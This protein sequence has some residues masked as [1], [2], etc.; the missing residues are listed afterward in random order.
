MKKF[1]VCFVLAAMVLSTAACAKKTEATPVSEATTA[2]AAQLANPWVDCTLKDIQDKTGLDFGTPANAM[3]ITYRLMESEQLGEMNFT[4]NGA[5]CCARV[6][7]S[8]Q[9]TDISGMNYTWSTNTTAESTVSGQ[10]RTYTISKTSDNKVL[11]CSWFDAVPGIQWSLSV[12]S[13]SDLGNFDIVGLADQTFV[14]M[15]GNA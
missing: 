3:D 13:D 2:A 12:S 6:K 1:I 9:N 15:Q 8:G 14:N 4:V 10:T 11:L 5:K 7:A